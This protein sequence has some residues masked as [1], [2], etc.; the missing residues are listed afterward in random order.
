M[1][2]IDTG[3]LSLYFVYSHQE[4]GFIFFSE[5]VRSYANSS[6]TALEMILFLQG[7]VCSNMKIE[8]RLMTDV[9]TSQDSNSK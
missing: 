4:T 2:V 3:H 1:P 8:R 6:S 7:S 9:H 5:T